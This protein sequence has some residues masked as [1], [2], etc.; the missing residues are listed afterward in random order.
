MNLEKSILGTIINN[1]DA[2]YKLSELKAEWFTSEQNRWLL[3]TLHRMHKKAEPIDLITLQEKLFK[4]TE[5]KYELVDLLEITR[6]A[7]PSSAHLDSYILNLQIDYLSRQYHVIT[8]SST[9]DPFTDFNNLISKCDNLVTECSPDQ[10][11]PLVDIIEDALKKEERGLACKI[12]DLINID[13][14]KPARLIMI[15][16]R[17][18]H[19]KTLFVGSLC[20]DFCEQNKK[21]V[22]FTLE[23]TDKELIRRLL[24][25]TDPGDIST[26]DLDIVDSSGYSVELI[27]SQVLKNNYDFVMIDYLQKIRPGKGD[28]LTNQIGYNVRQLKDLAKQAGLPVICVSQAKRD[29]EDRSVKIHNMGDFSDS[30]DIEYE[31]DF[32]M[33]VMDWGLWDIEEYRDGSLTENSRIIQIVKNRHEGGTPFIR[34]TI[35]D[36]TFNNFMP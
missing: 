19:G 34:S 27:K 1:Q 22:F 29:I 4:D 5:R 3:N 14:F 32:A 13:P 36:G 31:A 20:K 30:K 8:G 25:S 15:G 26:W 6:E 18:S 28:Q 9:D 7:P 12:Q 23:M 2:I 10:H 21:G 17:P 16:G 11:R 35:I 33:F 24:K